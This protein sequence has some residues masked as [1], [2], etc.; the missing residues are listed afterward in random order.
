[1]AKGKR[2]SSPTVR[3]T[4][5]RRSARRAGPRP[6]WPLWLA[7]IL[8]VAVTAY[9]LTGLRTAST[10]DPATETTTAEPAR[11]DQE[12]PAI[13]PERYDLPEVARQEPPAAEGAVQPAA[14]AARLALVIDDLGRSLAD[15]DR[16]AGLGVPVTFAVLPF[17]SHTAEVRDRIVAGG[18]E[19]ICHLPMEPTNGANPGPGAL[20][21]EMRGRQLAS[22]TRR[23]LA[24]V[25]GVVGVNNH[26]GSNLTA[27]RRAMRAILRV[28][29]NRGLYFLDSR[30]SA[31][32]V[33]FAVAQ[34]MRIPTVERRVFLDGELTNDWVAG[35]FRRALEI[36]RDDGAAVVI[37]HPHDVTLT[38][39]ESLVPEAQRAGYEFVE[40]SK[41]LERA[42]SP[43][44]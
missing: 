33:G 13:V 43:A 24:A 11:P 22:A 21:S 23:A 10:S 15:V 12:P 41:L 18:H 4:R 35:Q 42:G 31:D 30:T 6:R 17:E 5:R 1:M 32:S 34:E 19:F 37:G 40:V 25:P 14:G 20:T 28:I 7:L 27:D 36:A 16:V 8:L 3:K 44:G 38:A 9:I 39:L 29:G 26:M 2:R